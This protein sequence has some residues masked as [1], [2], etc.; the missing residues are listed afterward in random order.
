M[1]I[2]VGT[3]HAGFSLKKVVI[4]A[5]ESEGHKVVDVG[6]YD[7]SKVDFPDYAE[8]VGD[9]IQRGEAQRG[10][11]LCGSGIGVCIA[12]NK[13]SGVYA[14][15]CHDTYSAHQG[16][17]HDGMN[18]LCLGGRVIGEELAKEIVS[19]FLSAE[20]MNETKF[21]NRINKIKAIE[22]KHLE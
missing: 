21:F 4:N 22:T 5:V 9:L 12:L 8:K 10:I 7:L 2:A 19:S 11:A 15:V 13:M 18:V 6:S 17:E 16:V 14:S 1:I 20:Q 3:D